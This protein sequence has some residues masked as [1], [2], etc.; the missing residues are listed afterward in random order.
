VALVFLMAALTWVFSSLTCAIQ[1]LMTL[2]IALFGGA[3]ALWVINFVT[4]VALD[5]LTIMG[6]IIAA[7]LVLNNAILIIAEHR[8]GVASGLDRALALKKAVEIRSRPIYISALTS[9]FGMLPLMLSP[10]VG[11]QM[12]R[13]MAT[14]LV[15]SMTFSLI[16]CVFVVAAVSSYAR[17]K[18]VSASPSPPL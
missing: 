15:G 5:V 6:F 13:G 8:E 12:Y 10:G 11:A 2:P 18:T 17:D 4:P 9:I 16:F 7:G 3:V 14:V 1:I